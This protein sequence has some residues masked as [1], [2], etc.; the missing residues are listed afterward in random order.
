MSK[1]LK[2]LQS[3]I[4]SLIHENTKNTT[5]QYF[6]DYVIHITYIMAVST[7][8]PELSSKDA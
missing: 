4:Q 6:Q 7:P 8:L 3:E 1:Q 5:N 2:Q